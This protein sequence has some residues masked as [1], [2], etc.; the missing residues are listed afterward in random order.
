MTLSYV[1]MQNLRRNPLRTAL[2][3]LAFALPMV[4][5]VAAISL[6]IALI[7]VGQAS[8]KELR[9]AT[10]SKVT[11]INILP[12]RVRR[13][14]EALDTDHSRITGV[15]GFRW[16]GG[17]VP[18]AANVVQS[19]GADVDTFPTV[20]SDI[21]MTPAEIE[22]WN[23][24]RK[25]TVV[26]S[27]PAA[28]YNWQVGDRITLVS[29]VPPYV[30]LEFNVIKICDTP[31]RSAGMYL[32]HD[33]LEEAIK[34]AGMESYG[35]NLFWVKCTSLAAL[36][37][38]QARI[39]QRFAN[40]PDETVTY[41]E[42]A[43]TATFTQALGDIPGLM[44]GMA[45]VVLIIIA[46]VAGNTMMMSFRER[47]RELA[48]FKAIGFQR[49]RVFFIVLAESVSL[50]VLGALIGIVPTVALLI[51]FPLKNLGP[52]PIS[53]LRVSPA[54]VGI[55]LGMALLVGLAAGLW[56]AWQAMRLQTVSALRRVA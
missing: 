35:S 41:D 19:L 32:R 4:I 36:R 6:V 17:R 18:D 56:P 14:I 8:A 29:T 52:L 5:F 37:E 31:G 55:A 16:F 24:D 9:L 25:A 43:F 11:L 45:I 20:F 15:C 7:Q 46:L 49:P 21:Q 28:Q 33:Y 1:L 23:R 40:T 47:T 53:A 3:V 27:T 54:A 39:D 48:V 22:S 10:R 51:L 2:T 26:G 13:E 50:A 30:S 44:H 38:M 34:A 12:E 42:N